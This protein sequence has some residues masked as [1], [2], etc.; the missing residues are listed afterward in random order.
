MRVRGAEALSEL[1]HV[2]VAQH[3]GLT[4][5]SVRRLLQDA[6]RR[7]P[8]EAQNVI[9]ALTGEAAWARTL[10]HLKREN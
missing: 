6:R 2:K 7:V 8:R 9:N 3:Y 10:G 4:P 5:E 1:A